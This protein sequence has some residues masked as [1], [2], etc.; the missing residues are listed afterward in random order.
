MSDT[1]RF[2]V[3]LSLEL[4]DRFDRLVRKL[5]YPNRSEA[6][7]DLIRHRLVEDDWQAPDLQT[8]ALVSLVYELHAGPVLNRVT[9]LQHDSHTH[10]ISS[11]HVHIDRDNCLE[12]I[13]LKG[14]CKELRVLG[15]KLISLKGVKYGTVN[16][17]TSGRRVS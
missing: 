10:V 5:G 2:G 3:S 8:F 11:L 17:G 14:R 7:R 9:Q 16:L 6:I 4:L 1:V 15:D 12:V 13:V